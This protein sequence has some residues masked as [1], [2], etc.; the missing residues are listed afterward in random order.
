MTKTSNKKE[1][2]LIQLGQ[3]DELEATE[4]IFIF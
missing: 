3:E 1:A 2:S 4:N